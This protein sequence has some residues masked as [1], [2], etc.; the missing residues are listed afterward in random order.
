MDSQ[1]GEQI[2]QTYL[3]QEIYAMGYYEAH[4][5]ALRGLLLERE[6]RR[7]QIV[8]H[9]AQEISYCKSQ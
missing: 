4:T 5:I 6:M 1:P 2:E 8:E 3:Q 9:K 7:H